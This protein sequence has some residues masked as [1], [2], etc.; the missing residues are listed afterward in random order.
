MN[1]KLSSYISICLILLASKSLAESP[2]FCT[3]LSSGYDPE[4]SLDRANLRVRIVA[5]NGASRELQLAKSGEKIRLNNIDPAFLN[6]KILIAPQEGGA[7]PRK[8]SRAITIGDATD[9][10]PQFQAQFQPP[11]EFR[12]IYGGLSD[13]TIGSDT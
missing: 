2:G 9:S 10:K 4:Y 6:G 8:Q 1:P 3:V 12:F 7:N 5:P 11:I 13:Y